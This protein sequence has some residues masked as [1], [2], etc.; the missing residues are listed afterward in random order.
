MCTYHFAVKIRSKILAY[1]F[2]SLD[3]LNRKEVNLFGQKDKQYNGE[4]T[5]LGKDVYVKENL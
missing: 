4:V 5:K 2:V 1:Y 3:C